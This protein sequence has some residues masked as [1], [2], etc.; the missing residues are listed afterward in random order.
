MCVADIST[1]F[2]HGKIR[3]KCFVRAGPEFGKDQGKRMIIDRGLY[4]LAT[5]SASFHEKLASTLRKLGFQPSEVDFDLWMRDKGDH[6]EYVAC[7]VDDLLVFSKDPMSILDEIK[8]EYKLKGVGTPEYY[9][10]E[11]VDMMEDQLSTK[12]VMGIDEAGN[13]INNQ[14]ISVKW[15]KEGIRTAFS[16]KTYIQNTTKRL[17]GMIGKEFSKFDTPMSKTSHP[18]LDDSLLLNPIDH[19]KFRSI[20]GCANWLVTL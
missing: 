13:D 6:W 8:K 5:S 4:G 20:V 11:D 17:E 10:R 7:Y 18:E 2:L 16:A 9:L 14:S 19:S 12:D 15:L 1:A 3:E